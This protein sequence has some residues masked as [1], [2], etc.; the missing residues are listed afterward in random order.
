[1]YTHFLGNMQWIFHFL[2]LIFDFFIEHHIYTIVAAAIFTFLFCF[3]FFFLVT[4]IPPPLR[5][6]LWYFVNYFL[7]FRGLLKLLTIFF[8]STSSSSTL[9]PHHTIH[10]WLLLHYCH[11]WFVCVRL[12]VCFELH[13]LCWGPK[14]FVAIFHLFLT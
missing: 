3:I 10:Y 6:S 8:L 9:P 7:Y 12:D 1:M 14:L 4:N 13:K 11:T 2:L 5:L